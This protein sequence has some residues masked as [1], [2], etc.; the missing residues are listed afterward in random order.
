MGMVPHLAGGGTVYAGLYGNL[1]QTPS[2]IA[3][4]ALLHPGLIVERLADNNAAAYGRDMAAPFAFTPL[5]APEI[6]LAAVPQALIN[7]LSTANFT[8]DLIYHYQA[9]PMVAM[10]IGMV[11]G[12]GRIKKWRPGLTTFAVGAT[13]ACALAAS[14]AWGI[15]PIS[16]DY[17]VGYWPL[18]PRTEQSA[19]DAAVA[20]V[21]ASD[22]V[23]ADYNFVPHLTHRDVIYTFPNPW[24]NKNFGVS[25]LSSGDP[26]KVRWLV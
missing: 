5:A 18:S 10:G 4:T 15:S 11:E 21:G 20:R 1:G 7:L 23:A 2:E 16:R 9:L 19:L 17:H 26:A 24:V 25:P 14:C 6:L 13:V 12:I 8:W 3:K 22:G